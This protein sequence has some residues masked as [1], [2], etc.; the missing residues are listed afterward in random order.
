M[1]G[2]TLPPRCVAIAT[3]PSHPGR[4]LASVG[5]QYPGPGSLLSQ[6]LC[7]MLVVAGDHFALGYNP[8]FTFTTWSASPFLVQLISPAADLGFQIVGITITLFSRFRAGGNLGNAR[9]R[10]ASYIP[11]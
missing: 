9:K 4:A 8:I 6:G 5:G 7:A 11:I 2:S 10:L 3:Q 1:T